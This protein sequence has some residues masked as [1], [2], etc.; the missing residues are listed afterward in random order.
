MKIKNNFAL[1]QV[2]DTWIVMPLAEQNLNLNG[3]LTMTES[4]AILWKALEQGCDLAALT[5]ALTN[6]YDVTE[7][8]A[9]ADAA[10][11]VEKLRQLGCI[12]D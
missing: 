1:R 3:M 9:Q 4:G 7:E 6:E 10:K 5:K 8:K 11:F 2:A 12:E